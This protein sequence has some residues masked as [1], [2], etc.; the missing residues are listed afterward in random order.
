MTTRPPLSPELLVL[1]AARE[2]D[3]ICDWIRATAH[4][5]KRRGAVVAF[6]GGVDL[7][8][9]HNMLHRNAH[10]PPRFPQF[11]PRQSSFAA[12]LLIANFS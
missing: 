12:M 2:A 1:D 3:R 9:S 7:L 10:A 11:D 5:V 6:S 4:D 8:L